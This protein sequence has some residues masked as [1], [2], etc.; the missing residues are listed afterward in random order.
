MEIAWNP[1]CNDMPLG[2]MFVTGGG[3]FMTWRQGLMTVCATSQDF[4]NP[5]R[6][7]R[8]LIQEESLLIM[9][10]V[11]AGCLIL[12]FGVGKD[13][14][15]LGTNRNSRYLRRFWKSWN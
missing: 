4:Q 15:V 11:V 5:K 2:G 7:Y 14:G 1:T 8:A 10:T 12:M 9:I 3:G 13:F 6:V